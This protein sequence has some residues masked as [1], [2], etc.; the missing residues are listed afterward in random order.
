VTY[1]QMV[2]ALASMEERERRAA[3]QKHWQAVFSDG[4][5]AFVQ[6]QIEAG[7]KMAL[8]GG[9]L[10]EV[11]AGLDPS[12]IAGLKRQSL[13]EVA[14]LV[15]VWDSMVAVYEK[16]QTQS[17]Q[18]GNASG[19]VAHGRHRVMPRGVAVTGAVQCYRCGSAATDRGLCAGCLA[20][21]QDWDR[22]DEEYDREMHERQTADLENRRLQDDEL[23]YQNQQDYNTYTDYGQ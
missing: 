14:R 1:Q 6:G 11:F 20:T 18:Q 5:I 15:G 13:R 8:S 2:D 10:A 9:G 16:L 22:Q 17:E 3:M 21:Q 12:V 7:R 23:Y 4:F 19:M